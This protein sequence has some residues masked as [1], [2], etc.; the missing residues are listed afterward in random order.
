MVGV[1]E[2]FFVFGCVRMLIA[3]GLVVIIIII[4]ILDIE[5]DG[6]SGAGDQV[7]IIIY[8]DVWIIHV[9]RMCR[10]KLI[11]AV[12]CICYNGICEK[13]LFNC[14]EPYLLMW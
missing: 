13:C 1:E 4:I 12:V 8:V 9:K 6:F 5:Q 10:L 11:G 14:F 3:A 2:L 7:A